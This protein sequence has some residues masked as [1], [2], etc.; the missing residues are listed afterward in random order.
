[1]DRRTFIQKTSATGA[2]LALPSFAIAQA[3]PFVY[4][5]VNAFSGNFAVSGKFSDLGVR[6]AVKAYG[7]QLGR[8][9][10]YRRID[11]EGVDI[12]ERRIAARTVLWAAG[13]VGSGFGRMLGVPLD[14]SGRVYVER[15]GETVWIG[16]HSVS[17]IRGEL[18]L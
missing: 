2:A 11:T 18:T 15:E 12:G 16:G 4:Y 10:D 1:M 5:S 8:P 14:R 9:I 6:S 13:V 7:N 17:C 3:K